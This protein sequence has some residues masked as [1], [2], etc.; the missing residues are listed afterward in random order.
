MW[1]AEQGTIDTY[2]DSDGVSN[3]LKWVLLVTAIICFAVIGWGTYKTYQL[4]PPLPHAFLTPSGQALMKEDDIVA[5]KAGFQRA[6]LMD[7][8]SLYGMGSYF[9]EDYTAKYLVRLGRLTEEEIA[10]Q[11]F[12]QAFATLSEG[13]QYVV[14]KA[15]QQALQQIDLSHETSTLSQPVTNAI[16]Q[17]QVEIPPLLLNHN[18]VSGWTKA[19]SLNDQSALQTADF[20]IY[21]SLTTIAHRP[22]KNFSYT[23]NWPYE[24]TMGNIPTPNTFYWTWV[25]FCFVFFGFGA[26]LYIYHRYL[27]APDNA[28]RTPV[29]LGF[30]PLTPSQRKVGQYFVT[31]AILLLVQIG[32]GAIMAHDYAER[33]NFYGITLNAFLP[34]NFLRDVHIQTPLV[35]ITLSWISSAVFLAPIISKTEAKSQGFLVDLL[36]WVT[37][38]IVSGAIVGDYLGIMGLVN[39]TWFW[40]GNQGLL[41]WSNG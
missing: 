8:G 30:K 40:I 6:D 31:V 7:Y 35:W 23:N 28:S 21:S 1:N 18:F 22:G 29:L 13:D 36:F 12:N 3:I 25:S 34:F 5:G 32:V 26:V 27:N 20:L 14:R 2:T 10:Q 38:I 33:T 9:G 19:Y 15:M 37:L 41:T 11:R 24:P 16:Q 39:E 17:L 4:A